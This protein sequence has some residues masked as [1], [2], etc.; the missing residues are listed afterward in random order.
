[1]FGQNFA[2]FSC[3][4]AFFLS[5]RD[6]FLVHNSEKILRI[7]IIKEL[8]IEFSFKTMRGVS[9][10]LSEHAK[11]HELNRSGTPIHDLMEK[12][13]VHHATIYRILQEKSKA[14]KKRGQPSKLTHLQELHL[15]NKMRQNPSK[16]ANKL[17]NTF[18]FPASAQTVQRELRK[19]GFTHKRVVPKKK[20]SEIHK[21]K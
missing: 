7:D 3:Q 19:A 18:E 6:F 20:L 5:L 17:A 15:I 8:F 2:K 14:K 21:Q 13:H 12:Y 11:I 16:L 4:L 1:M 10:P 9:I